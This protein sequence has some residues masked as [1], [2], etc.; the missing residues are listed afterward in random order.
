MLLARNGVIG[1]NVIG[2]V[3][4]TITLLNTIYWDSATRITYSTDYHR[5]LPLEG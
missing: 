5:R 2:V 4:S 1:I 3:T